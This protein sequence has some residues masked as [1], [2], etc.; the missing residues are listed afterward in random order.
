MI[1]KK[2]QKFKF[3]RKNWGYI[4]LFVLIFAVAFVGSRDKFIDPDDDMSLQSI[5]SNNYTVSADQVSEFYIV[6]ELAKSMDLYSSNDVAN[7]YVSVSVL[8]Q[9]SQVLDTSGKLSKPVTVDV[10]HLSRGIVSYVVKDGETME[11]IAAKYGLTTDQIRWSNNLTSTNVYAGQTLLVPSSPGIAYT[12]KNGDT[13][14]SVSAKYGSSVDQIVS[15]NDLEKDHSI[16]P[17]TVIF[18]PSGAP[19]ETERPEYVPPTPTYTYSYTG[20]NSYS[21]TYAGGGGRENVHVVDRFTYARSMLGDGNPMIAG[22]CTWYAWYYR[23]HIGGTPLPTSAFGNANAWAYSL[24]RSG[25]A[26]DRNPSVNAVFQTT[27]GYYGHVGIVTGVNADGSITIREMNYAGAYIVTEATV[28]ASQ[29]RN[30][31]YIH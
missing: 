30:F 5:A 17:G 23:K 4:L 31:N 28:P 19:P 18:L 9:D 7:N 14:E 3:L 26:V 20:S 22:Q 21:T 10:G 16:T 29:V 1:A 13:V 15:L 24:G 25:F 8:Q 2:S 6:A 12:V 11:S 27:A